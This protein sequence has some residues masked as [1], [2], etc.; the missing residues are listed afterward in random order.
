MNRM[1]RIVACLV[2]AASTSAYAVAV[3]GVIGSGEYASTQVLKAGVFTLYWQVQGDVIHIGIEATAAGWVALGF[4]PGTVMA[5]SDI[6]MF[7][8]GADG[9]CVASDQW[10]S[11]VMG[12][13]RPDVDLGGTSD[14]L[15][16]AGRRIGDRVVVEFTRR[17]TTGDRFDKPVSL[18][19]PMK[20][21]WATGSVAAT[22]VKHDR[23]GTA[24]VSF[25][26]SK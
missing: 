6:V 23:A 18:A 4:D 13:H 21:M 8:V 14:V 5:N 24:R 10:S 9:S 3:D 26:G 20:V 1:K 22:T 25:G 17:L 16:C 19:A 2:L 11:G 15:A 7:V 12:P